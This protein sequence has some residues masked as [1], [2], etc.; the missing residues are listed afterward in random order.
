MAETG[1]D[2]NGW[3]NR[4]RQ[5]IDPG[6]TA[7]RISRE[8]NPDGQLYGEV[9][10]FTGELQIHRREAADLAAAM[11]CKVDAAVTQRTTLLVVGDQDL[12][13]LAGHIKSKKHREAEE[14]I[15]KGQ[16][17]RILRET[18][19]RQLFQLSSGDEAQCGPRPELPPGDGTSPLSLGALFGERRITPPPGFGQGG[20]SLDS[21]DMYLPSDGA[22]ELGPLVGVRL[23]I[24]YAYDDTDASLTRR[25]VVVD[26]A[27]RRGRVWYLQAHCELRGSPREFRN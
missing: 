4:V 17:I 26:K 9:V 23:A 14:L 18:D 1:L 25:F 7:E 27:V 20:T 2:I 24:T 10:V 11:G 19:F 3:L 5:P 8:A 21:P 6:K 13:R 15:Q 12:S 22:E 16:N